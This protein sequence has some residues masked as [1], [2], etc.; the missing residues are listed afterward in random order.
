MIKVTTFPRAYGPPW[1][2]LVSPRPRDWF[3][4]DRAWPE[5]G[6]PVL[7]FRGFGP[8][9][10]RRFLTHE[11]VEALVSKGSTPAIS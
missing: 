9:Q 7:M 11:E 3:L 6:R 5:S 4:G 1:N 2:L 8:V 10:L